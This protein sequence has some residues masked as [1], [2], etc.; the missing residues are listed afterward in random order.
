M[1]FTIIDKDQMKAAGSLEG[2]TPI[3]IE[4]S[5]I[6]KYPGKTDIKLHGAAIRFNMKYAFYTISELTQLK[7]ALEKILYVVEQ[8]KNNENN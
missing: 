1:K 2:Y 5:Y 7:Q 6:N 3:N 4:V 8:D